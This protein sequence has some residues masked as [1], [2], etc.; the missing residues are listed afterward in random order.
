MPFRPGLVLFVG[1]VDKHIDDN[2]SLIAHMTGLNQSL[3]QG[4]GLICI[5]TLSAQDETIQASEKSLT[6]VLEKQE[7]LEDLI[8]S[9]LYRLQSERT[10]QSLLSSGYS[11]PDPC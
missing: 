7:P 1:E 2:F 10:R 6:D 8:K 5:A 3:Q 4:I 11:M 9:V